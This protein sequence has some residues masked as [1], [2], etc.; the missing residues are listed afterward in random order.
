MIP[1]ALGLTFAATPRYLAGVSRLGTISS[2]RSG[3]SGP[4][5]QGWV[6]PHL[7]AWV[8][9]QGFDAA[10]I[11]TLRGMAELTDPDL[12]VPEA[13]VEEAWQLAT[14]LTNDPAIGGHPVEALPRGGVGPVGV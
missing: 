5:V 12:R 1:P 14:T 2:L 11:R 3:A 13:S 7:I 8:E 9:T 10:P 4:S 6:L